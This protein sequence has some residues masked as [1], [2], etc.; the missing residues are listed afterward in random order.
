MKI[1]IF[2]KKN[3]DQLFSKHVVN[4]DITAKR[5]I[6]LS[7]SRGIDF[8][9]EFKR[10]TVFENPYHFNLCLIQD[11]SR[12]GAKSNYVYVA[13]N[14]VLTYQCRYVP[15]LE[16]WKAKNLGE[17]YPILEKNQ[18]GKYHFLCKSMKY[19]QIQTE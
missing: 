10:N 4:G 5:A 6:A 18:N 15:S 17:K 14:S 1:K 3:P 16:K 2:P 12:L 11:L 8:A 7:E 19:D 13:S 9:N